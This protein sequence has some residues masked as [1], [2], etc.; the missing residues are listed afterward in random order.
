MMREIF[1]IVRL[2][3]EIFFDLMQVLGSYAVI[4]VAIPF[5]GISSFSIFSRS[6]AFQS[7]HWAKPKLFLHMSHLPQ[8]LV[9]F[10]SYLF[11]ILNPFLFLGLLMIDSYF[12]Y[13][14]GFWIVHV[15]LHLL[16][17]ILLHY[18]L[19]FLYIFY[20]FVTNPHIFSYL[21]NITNRNELLPYYLATK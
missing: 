16:K 14:F 3:D 5:F 2:V 20:Y 4:C 13:L 6:F 10:L 15:F 8:L 9:S 11:F 1:Y 7:R 18:L 21:T 12:N 17:V 19:Y